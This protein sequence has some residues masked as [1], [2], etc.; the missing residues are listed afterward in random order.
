MSTVT[1]TTTADAA[2]NDGTAPRIVLIN[3]GAFAAIIWPGAMPLRPGQRAELQPEARAVYARAET[4]TTF[5]DITTLPDNGPGHGG[6]TGDLDDDLT[7]IAALTPTSGDLLQFTGGGWANR[8]AAQVKFTLDLDQVNNTSD[9]AKPVSSATQTAL[10]SL[11]T[12]LSNG[13]A[14][15]QPLDT[16]LTTIAALAPVNGDV[17]QF[18][19]GAWS[20]RTMAQF[21]TDLAFGVSDVTGLTATL[22]GKVATTGAETIAGIKT[23]TSSPVVPTPGA[24]TDAANK[25]YVDGVAGSGT[26]DADASTKG[27]LQLAGD[28]GGTAASP[29]VPGL[30]AKAPLASP[31][32]TGTPTAPTA[33]AATNNTQVATTA[34]ADAAA[35]TAAAG[36]ANTSHTHSESDVTGLISDLAAKAPLA[37]PTFTGTPAAPTATGGTNTTQLATTAF[38]QTALAGAQASDA[39]LT[40]IAALTP[41]NNDTL[42]YIGG[43]WQ[44]R[45]P[46]Q[47]K[48]TI[49]VGNVDNTS[50]ATKNAATAT[51]TNK[52]LDASTTTITDTTDATKVGKFDASAITTATTRTYTLP[53]ATGT[54]VLA[55]NTSTLTNKTIDGG[56]NTLTNIAQASVTNLGTDLAAKADDTAVVKLTGTQTVAGVKTFSSSPVVPTP[57]SGTD[58]ANKTYVDGVASSGTPDADAGTKGKIQLAG[59]LSGTAA[60]PTVVGLSSKAPL[61]SP[62]LTGS[63]TAP[64][65]AAADNSTKIATT[66]YVDTGLGTKAASS[67]T[68]AESDVTG[69]TSDLAAKAPLASPTFTGTPAAPTATAGTNTTQ[70]ATTAFVTTAVAAGGGSTPDADASTKGKIQLAGDLGG[71]AAS[72]TVV[73]LSGKAPLASPTFTGTPAAPTASAGTNTTQVATTAFATTASAENARHF[74]APDQGFASWAFDPLNCTTSSQPSSGNIY[75]MRLQVPAAFNV[76]RFYWGV[77]TAGASITAGQNFVGIYDTTGT[78]LVSA[79]VDADVTASAGPKT[80][81]LSSTA[82]SAGWVWGAF[83]FVASTTPSILRIPAQSNNAY[84]ANLTAATYRFAN[85]GSGKTSLTSFT[86]SSNSSGSGFWCA[87]G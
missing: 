81:T 43:A 62:A 82:L 39:D 70:V 68:H 16:D 21:K 35:T 30:A 10:N 36:K 60:S 66:A 79:G 40:A 63:P 38:V 28:L 61:A 9:A 3:T 41:T 86:P 69:L 51:L 46:G 14:G 27:K 59:D 6:S 83:L 77:A 32:L 87:I 1:V 44:N 49:G 34:Y 24:S 7:A 22:A 78:L 64:T 2:I 56:S 42:Q 65:Q 80:T 29:T 73:G 47:A 4:G 18:T 26:P 17:L 13:L 84:N 53:N 15:K 85:A 25:S 20:N 55:G 19:A 50:D 75:L 67:H 45:T 12:S 71:T 48:S 72:P 58:A 33:T 8:N 54:F 5:I 74:R 31:A 37:S 52:K 23:F 11:T 57:S 76:T